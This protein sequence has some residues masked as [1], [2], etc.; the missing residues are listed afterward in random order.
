MTW[1][2][3]CTR[4]GCRGRVAACR[5][6]AGRGRPRCNGGSDHRPGG[7]HD[8]FFPCVR[9]GSARRCQAS[10]GG[11]RA[12]GLGGGSRDFVEAVEI[13]RCCRQGAPMNQVA[14]VASRVQR[15]RPRARRSWLVPTGLACRRRHCSTRS[16][17]LPWPRWRSPKRCRSHLHRR[18]RRVRCSSWFRSSPSAGPSHGAL[19]GLLQQPAQRAAALVGLAL[20]A[21]ASLCR[22]SFSESQMSAV[23]SGSIGLVVAGCRRGRRHLCLCRFSASASAP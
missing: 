19:D 4:S 2:P 8:R 14:L 11:G 3:H 13:S 10:F 17:L 23:V 6:R 1:V 22:C 9:P 5:A 12:P 21:E 20:V 18:G 7:G 16:A 15:D